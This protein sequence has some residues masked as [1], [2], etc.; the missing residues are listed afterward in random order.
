MVNPFLGKPPIP[1]YARVH[2]ATDPKLRGPV[3]ALLDPI[4]NANQTLDKVVVTMNRGGSNQRNPLLKGLGMRFEWHI[5]TQDQVKGLWLYRDRANLGNNLKASLLNLGPGVVALDHLLG[6]GLSEAGDKDVGAKKNFIRL[7]SKYGTIDR[8]FW[9]KD[10]EGDVI[11]LE[12]ANALD[13]ETLAPIC[14]VVKIQD[15]AATW[16]DVPIDFF[17]SW[18][19]EFQVLHNAKNPYLDPGFLKA[20]GGAAFV[21]F[22]DAG[23]A[24]AEG[25]GV[26]FNPVTQAPI[27]DQHIIQVVN[28]EGEYH[29]IVRFRS[30]TDS[31]YFVDVEICITVVLDEANCPTPPTCNPPELTDTWQVYI[32]PVPPPPPTWNG[33]P[34]IDPP[35][36]PDIPSTP[37]DDPTITTPPITNLPT[38][39]SAEQP[40][41]GITGRIVIIF[42]GQRVTL[43]PPGEPLVFVKVDRWT[44]VADNFYVGGAR[45]VRQSTKYLNPAVTDMEQSGGELGAPYATKQKFTVCVDETQDAAQLVC[46][47][48]V[49]LY[50]QNEVGLWKQSEERLIAGPAWG[51][52]MG[53]LYNPAATGYG[54]GS[55]AGSGF[56]SIAD[57]AGSCPL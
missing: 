45:M 5:G 23:E 38:T 9:I 46:F 31:V 39:P 16:I 36:T 40:A 56:R 47:Y 28:A 44:A 4:E 22:F 1:D 50:Q 41:E 8:E 6:S 34:P 11:A 42:D 29:A 57:K 15:L 20:Y 27:R 30:K 52:V 24:A 55:C 13:A 51:Q 54:P 12:G 10:Y 21:S 33:D 3:P 26:N 49:S 32:P 43:T 14:H 18:N 53:P 17:V 19:D 37:T 48:T 7:Q 2:R 25:V 35:N